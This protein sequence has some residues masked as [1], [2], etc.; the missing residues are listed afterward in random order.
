MRLAPA[1]LEAAGADRLR[2][3]T[4]SRYAAF[5]AYFVFFFFFFAPLMPRALSPLMFYRLRFLFDAAFSLATPMP[6][7]F[8]LSYTLHA[9][10]ASLLRYTFATTRIE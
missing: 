4:M 9:M 10:A 1:R 5:Y 3:I 8:C 6:L 2:F 7:T